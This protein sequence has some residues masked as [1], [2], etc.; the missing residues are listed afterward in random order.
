MINKLLIF[1][2]LTFNLTLPGL[3][4][5]A[6]NNL[7][8]AQKLSTVL[9]SINNLQ[10]EFVY[11]LY[12]A[13]GKL[14]QTSRGKLSLARPNYLYWYLA[15]SDSTLVSDGEYLW[16]YEPDLAQVVRTKIGNNDELNP[17]SVLTSSEVE[18]KNNF[19]ISEDSTDTYV[20][21][22]LNGRASFKTMRICI[23]Q[24][25]IQELELIDE[26]SQR[27]SYKFT[28]LYTNLELS[29]TSFK[30]ELPADVEILSND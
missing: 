28:K 21:Q 8:P 22:P 2:V 17:L 1:C 26:L 11:N 9:Q 29:P 7:L 12:D 6:H 13:K 3:S 4:S 15:E 16:N 10:S 20:L 24:G 27:A 14:L 18:L 30:L 5:A 23:K 19:T 25:K